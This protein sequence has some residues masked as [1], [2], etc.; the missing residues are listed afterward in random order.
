MNLQIPVGKLVLFPDATIET[1]SVDSF[2]KG[3]NLGEAAIFTAMSDE[4]GV[5][6]DSNS[7]RIAT[8]LIIQCLKFEHGTITI[9]FK[10]EGNLLK[11]VCQIFFFS[12]SFLFFF[13]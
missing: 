6:V 9:Y 10:F 11:S 3:F 4:T 8:N 2:S 7:I 12:F 5:V 1:P 13:F